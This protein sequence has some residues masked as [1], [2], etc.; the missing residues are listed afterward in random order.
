MTKRQNEVNKFAFF[1]I[2]VQ[3]RSEIFDIYQINIFRYIERVIEFIQHDLH[4]T[5]I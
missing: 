4:I 1:K 5:F 3:T 2:I